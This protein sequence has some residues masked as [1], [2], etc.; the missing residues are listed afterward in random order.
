MA[1]DLNILK[2]VLNLP[3]STETF[4]SPIRVAQ[5]IRTEDLDPT[6]QTTERLNEIE[7][8]LAAHYATVQM[9]A[10]KTLLARQVGESS[11][12]YQA[13][14]IFGRFSQGTLASTEYGKIALQ[15]DNSGVLANKGNPRAELKVVG[16]REC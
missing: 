16:G 2:E 3:N 6:G 13:S 11:E 5:L 8:N 1:V 12:R 15:L 7:L 10:G 4:I 9:S 14:G